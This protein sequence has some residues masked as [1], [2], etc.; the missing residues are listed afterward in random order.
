MLRYVLASTYNVPLNTDNA[1]VEN[2]LLPASNMLNEFNHSNS[3][4]ELKKGMLELWKYELDIVVK[5]GKQGII[6]YLSE[7][8]K[9]LIAVV[10]LESIN[11]DVIPEINSLIDYSI[12]DT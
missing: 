4:L 10:V 2:F 3:S 11:Y 9:Q 1:S 8:Y 6:D 12:G 5:G 7:T